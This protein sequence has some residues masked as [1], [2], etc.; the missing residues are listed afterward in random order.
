ML[1]G[2]ARRRTA[3]RLS[4]FLAPALEGLAEPGGQLQLSGLGYFDGASADDPCVFPGAHPEVL[5][6]FPPTL[7]IAGSRDFAAS[8]V[9]HFHLGLDAAGADARLYLFDGLWHAFQIFADLPE[10][11]PVYRIMAGF[12]DRCL[13]A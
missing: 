1:G 2:S 7:L 6:Q 12:F 3:R 10:S 5:R 4:V 8:S 9:T 13:A 11:Q